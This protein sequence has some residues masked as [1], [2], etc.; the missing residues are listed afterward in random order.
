MDK[1]PE[2]VINVVLK[3]QTSL[4][5]NPALPNV[6]TKG[7]LEKIVEKRFN[8]TKEELKKIGEINDIND[9]DMT[10][11]LAKLI[12]KCQEIERPFRNELE[13]ICY[14]YVVDLFGVP[15]D[16]VQIDFKLVDTVDL[17]KESIKLDP[18]DGDDEI[19]FDDLIGIESIKGEV[20]KRRLL[21]ALAIGSSMQLSSNIKSYIGEIYDINPSLADLYRKILAL[22]NYLL[23][24]KEDIGIGEENKMQM[25]TVEVSL[26]SNQ[27]KVKIEAQGKIFPVLL[28]E[29]IHGFIELFIS[30]GLPDDMQKT[31]AILGK[32]D[33]LKTEPW[34]MRLGPSLWSILSDS[35][36]D[37]DTTLLPYLFKR[38]S[39]IP[40][41]KFNLF[42]KEVFAK[43]RKGKRLMGKIV[44]KSKEQR[45]YDRFESKMVKMKTEKSIISDEYIH[46]DEL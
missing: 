42:M 20:Y 22:N 35:F 29:S 43:T 23:F 32:S 45:D 37:V 34:D 36:E 46:P 10:A 5:D 8:E 14:N 2:D 41:E 11:V 12:L 28:S 33:Y 27:Q 17:G 15:E 19:E 39:K 7:F 16:T 13:K 30:H 25:G 21:D 31:M 44:E 1:L 24:T 18:I 40:L 26:G 3:N 38:I 6:F 4:G 9:T